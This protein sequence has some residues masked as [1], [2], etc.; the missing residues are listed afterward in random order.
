MESAM[1]S[2]ALLIL[3]LAAPSANSL[4]QARQGYSACLGAQL[5]D[6][7][8]QHIETSAFESLIAGSCK[9]EEAAFREAAVAT[10][11]AAGTSR[12]S[13]EQNAAFEISDLLDTTKQRYRD[14]LET[15]TQP[16]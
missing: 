3:L 7:L 15:N 11:V 1:I 5:R 10:D 16:R 13:A 12:A 2:S 4:N 14:Y 9:A 8:R 6:N